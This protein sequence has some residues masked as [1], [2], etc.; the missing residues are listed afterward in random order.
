MAVSAAEIVRNTTGETRESPR[1]TPQT[2]RWLHRWALLTV[3]AACPLLLLGAEVT[4]KGVGMVDPRGFRAPWHLFNQL[5]EGSL[6]ARGLGYV[7]EHA[8]RLAGFFIGTCV[9]VL[10]LALWRREP[11]PWVKWLGLAA[12]L[13]VSLQ[14]VVGI[15]R[16]ELN[17]LMGGNLALVHG[18]FAHLVLALLVSIA[19]FTSPSWQDEPRIVP[20]ETLRLR[21]GSLVVVGLV[22]LQLVLGALVRH[23]DFVFGARAHLLAAF[24]VV[25]AAAWLVKQVLDTPQH[26]RAQARAARVLAGLVILQL[27]LGMEAWLSKFSGP[28]VA[29]KR[30]LTP[31]AVQPD[32]M[33][34]IHY[35]V[36]SLVF[37]TAVVVALQAHRGLGWLGE[38]A[39]RGRLEGSA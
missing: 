21:R 1:D 17:A 30:A 23:K 34:S 39:P 15:F 4:T 35:L 8:H 25:V 6:L 28:L 3:C 32:L 38:T 14:G 37:A 20:E 24:A 16:V 13:T 22:Y 5:F 19:L 31:L 9:I 11:R 27:F 18:C 26:T 10:A 29:D 36:G 7:I 2:P 12:F 33:R